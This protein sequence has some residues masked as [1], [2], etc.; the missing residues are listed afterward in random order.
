MCFG[1]GV[2]NL[3]LADVGP[4]KLE[5]VVP[6]RWQTPG[7]VPQRLEHPAVGALLI[8]VRIFTREQER[9]SAPSAAL[10]LLARNSRPLG[11]FLV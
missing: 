7:S 1:N 5:R 6:T 10:F 9:V 2:C 11:L 4:P 8:P 3:I